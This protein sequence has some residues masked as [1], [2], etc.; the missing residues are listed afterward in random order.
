MLNIVN[1]SLFYF[2]TFIVFSFSLISCGGDDEPKPVELPDR[3]VVEWQSVPESGTILYTDE[4]VVLQAVKTGGYVKELEW[5]I[6]GVKVTNSQEI[7]INEDT[8][9]ISLAHTFDTPG[10]YDVSLRVANEGGETTIIRVLNFEVRPIPPLDLLAGQVSKTWRFTS[11]KLNDGPEL[12]RDYEADNTLQF[13]RENQTDPN[14]NT[15]FNC[16]FDKG[17]LTNGETDSN[18]RWEF[19]FNETYIKF[20]RI[21]IF[22]NNARIIELTPTEMTLGRREGESEVVYKLTFVQ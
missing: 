7:I 6:N 12:I 18:G 16:V 22:P 19:A 21:N 17:T 13:F 20:F 3:P 4:A 15:T 2:I 5:Q 9:S 8:T 11:I 1:R 10:R 14:T